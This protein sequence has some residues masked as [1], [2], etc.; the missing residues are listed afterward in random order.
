MVDLLYNAPDGATPYRIDDPDWYYI[1]NTGLPANRLPT[2]DDHVF[3]NAPTVVG[4]LTVGAW[5]GKGTKL[6]SGTL[7]VEGIVSGV[8]A[9]GGTID[10]PEVKGG[11]EASNGGEFINVVTIKAH[12]DTGIGFVAYTQAS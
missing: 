5:S 4:D 10:A 11:A 6:A 8:A 2:S 7:T 12:D 9:T 1:Q 3:S